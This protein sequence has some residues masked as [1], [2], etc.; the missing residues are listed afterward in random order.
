[1]ADDT[2]ANPTAADYA[3]AAQHALTAGN[4]PLAIE[5]VAAALSFD[6]LERSYVALLDRIL[7]KT[8]DPIVATA[9]REDAFFGRFAVHAHALAAAGRFNEALPVLAQ[10]VVFRPEIPYFEWL[11]GWT[12]NGAALGAVDERSVEAAT[13]NVLR[14]ESPALERN[15]QALA[16]FIMAAL[17]ARGRGARDPLLLLAAMVLRR[18]GA[19]DEAL[20]LLSDH[21]RAAPTWASRCEYARLLRA[22]GKTE[23]AVESLRSAIELSPEETSTYLDL[24]DALLE[25]GEH[26]E[27]RAAYARGGQP[28]I[29]E[30]AVA[31]DEALYQTTLPAPNDSAARVV[32]DVLQ[33]ASRLP[34][35]RPIRA[36]VRVDRP[37]PPSVHIAFRLGLARLG[38]TG[39]LVF[40]SEHPAPPAPPPMSGAHVATVASLAERQFHIDEWFGAASG[41]EVRDLIAIMSDPPAPPDRFESTDWV[42]RVQVAA[43]MHL[44]TEDDRALFE[45]MASASDWRVTAAIVALSALAR[46]R[47]ERRDEV[48]AALDA[49]LRIADDDDTETGALVVCRL[50]LG[51]LESPRLHAL[52]RRRRAL[53]PAPR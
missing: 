9:V 48:V 3:T 25:I 8:R 47:S 33:R 45:L 18:I 21:V 26:T 14:V 31:H 29:A 6:P 12:R 43:A 51:G 28:E 52:W 49:R 53:F 50:H 16:A 41:G 37:E 23:A 46:A 24:G 10:A 13:A 20:A 15:L 27:A 34:A 7:E 4:L 32:R 19:L 2:I 1:M 36:R 17:H 42:Q 39:E 5:Q 35:D 30:R 11:R 38:R 44:A 22:A 40:E